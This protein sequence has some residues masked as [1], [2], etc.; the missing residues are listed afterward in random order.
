MVAIV[1]SIPIVY[2]QVS[3]D[4]NTKNTLTS[5]DHRKS[6]GYCPVNTDTQ[7]V[8]SKYGASYTIEGCPLSRVYVDNWDKLPDLTKQSIV[9]ELAS[10]GYSIEKE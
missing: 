6:F 3:I 2:A 7:T 1:F 10:K 5:T 9:S 4:A 8:L